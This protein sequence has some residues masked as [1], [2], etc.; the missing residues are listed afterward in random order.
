METWY[1][2]LDVDER[3]HGSRSQ[4]VQAAGLDQSVLH[5]NNFFDGLE[6]PRVDVG[7]A[8]DFFQ[9]KIGAEGV[10]DVED[11]FG[12]GGDEF[13]LDLVAGTEFATAAPAA[14]VE[15][16]RADFQTAQGFLERF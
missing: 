8:V 13:A 7:E 11:A 14:T 9:R 6:K 12:A 3:A 15:T 2:G 16:G 10:A 4:R 5:L 1:R